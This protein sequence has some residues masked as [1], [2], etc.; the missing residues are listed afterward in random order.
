VTRT[1]ALLAALAA[2]AAAVSGCGGAAVTA[3]V[4]PEPAVRESGL[5]A[6]RA[7]VEAVVTN[8]PGLALRFAAPRAMVRALELK[9]VARRL[10]AYSHHRVLR[11]GRRGTIVFGSVVVNGSVDSPSELETTEYRFVVALSRVG[12]GAK[13]TYW[14]FA[15]TGTQVRPRPRD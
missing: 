13:V 5:T 7:F 4:S 1:P 11:V 3:P 8:R 9:D 12:P 10:G 6:A 15:P 2:F 14:E